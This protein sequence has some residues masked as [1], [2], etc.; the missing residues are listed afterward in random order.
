VFSVTKSLRAAVALLQ[1]AQTYGDQVS[2]LKIKDYVTVTAPH[3]GWE[4]VTFG[5]ALN[6]ATG[7]G[8]NWPQREPNQPFADEFKSS[9]YF[10]LVRART[11]KQKLDAAFSAGQYPCEPGEVLRYN[12]INTF[13][14]AAAMDSFLKR[15][16]GPDAQ[17]W[18]MVVAD[19]F[20][21]NGA[22]G[23][24]HPPL[25]M[26]NGVYGD[27]ACAPTAHGQRAAGQ[28]ARAHHLLGP[29]EYLSGS[30]GRTPHHVCVSRRRAV[31]HVQRRA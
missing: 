7:I 16:V 26:P 11:A 22:G 21:P 3:D 5:E 1:L 4:R 30:L 27:A 31:R 12:D 20:R 8:D 13:V 24:G 14:L 15:Q 25:P 6:M 2:N 23:R 28:G 9:A 17:L 18:D 10:K 19:V 29:R